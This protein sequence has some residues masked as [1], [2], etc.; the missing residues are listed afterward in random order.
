[1]E[2]EKIHMLKESNKMNSSCTEN[3][4]IRLDFNSNNKTENLMKINHE[5]LAILGQRNNEDLGYYS[6]D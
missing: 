1:M 3:N 6:H 2:Q 5:K 4:K